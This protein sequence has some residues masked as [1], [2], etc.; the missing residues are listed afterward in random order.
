[1]N[2]FINTSQHKVGGTEMNIKVLGI[3]I[4]KNIFELHGVDSK[5]NTV[6]KKRLTREK[7]P[8]VIA[9][10]PPCLIG[11]EACGGSHHWARKFKAMGHNAR[12]M[13]PQF[14]KPYV[15]SNKNDSRDAEAICEAVQRPSMRF[16]GVKNIEQQDV[17]A[18]HRVRERLVRNRSAI[19]NQIRGLLMEY[20]IVIAKGISQIRKKLTSII[21]DSKNELSSMGRELFRDLQAQFYT[22]DDKVLEY[23]KKIEVLCRQNETCQRLMQLQGV[24]ALTATA[25]VATIGDAKVFKNGREMAAFIGLVPRQHSS[26]GKQVLLGISKR[27]DR[28]LRC[29]LVHGARSVLTRGKHLSAKKAA[30]LKSLKERRGQNRT[31]VA[32]ANKN[33]RVMWAMMARQEDFKMI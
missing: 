30:W 31:I 12:L 28:Y 27:G 4:A 2:M 29:L 5:G 33:A 9:Q 19:V 16:V 3:D 24:G 14:V 22:A 25:L 26:G 6:Y 11:I 21:E 17:L 7:L 23:D 15:K 32:L 10:M 20:G 8:E 1:M 18:I 13:N